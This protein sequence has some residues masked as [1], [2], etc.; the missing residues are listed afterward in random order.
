MRGAWRIDGDAGQP[1][2]GPGINI[3]HGGG[4]MS[5]SVGWMRSGS[6][7]DCGL[8]NHRWRLGGG[9]RDKD[10]GGTMESDKGGVV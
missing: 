1:S 10:N 3:Y 2:G 4:G 9:G 6:R 8:T 7:D 5:E